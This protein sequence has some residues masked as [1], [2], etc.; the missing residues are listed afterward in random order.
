[1]ST[2]VKAPKV[3]SVYDLDNPELGMQVDLAARTATPV[4][5]LFGWTWGV[6]EVPTEIDIRNDIDEKICE[7]MNDKTCT[8]LNSGRLTVTRSDAEPT[9]FRI[10]LDLT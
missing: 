10:S 5:R 3:T 7:I 1:M 6:P 8:G 9:G 4:F 2:R